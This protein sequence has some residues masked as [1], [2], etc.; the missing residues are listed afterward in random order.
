MSALSVLYSSH[1][2]NKC[3]VSYRLAAKQK[4]LLFDTLP[5]VYWKDLSSPFP[6]LSC[7][8]AKRIFFGKLLIKGSGR[9]LKTSESL[10]M[11]RYCRPILV[12]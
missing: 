7:M 6:V 3:F 8:Y 1:S 10:E 9:K 11:G 2:N 4:H 12:A 5:M